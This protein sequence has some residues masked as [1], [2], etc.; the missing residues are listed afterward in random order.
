M[1]LDTVLSL[2][3]GPAGSTLS[4]GHMERNAHPHRPLGRDTGGSRSPR[5]TA[6]LG[7][8]PQPVTQ[9]S[10]EER[11]TRVH[12]TA[13]TGLKGPQGPGGW[14]VKEPTLTSPAELGRLNDRPLN[15]S[16]EQRDSK[17]STSGWSGFALASQRDGPLTPAPGPQGLLCCSLWKVLLLKTKSDT[18]LAPRDPHL[19]ATAA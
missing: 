12:T 5:R 9:C 10:K 13:A 19:C 18:L 15:F 7:T 4:S 14:A 2:R 6:F 8:C 11:G 16:L 17:A 1:G 3:G